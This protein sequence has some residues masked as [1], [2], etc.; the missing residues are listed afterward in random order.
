MRIHL[1]HRAPRGTRDDAYRAINELRVD[2]M[3]TTQTLRG[4]SARGEGVVVVNVRFVAPHRR[5]GEICIRGP[6]HQR[7]RPLWGSRTLLVGLTT[8][9]ARSA[10]GR[11]RPRDDLRYDAPLGQRSVDELVT[12]LD[13]PSSG[14]RH[15]P[16][17]R[18]KSLWQYRTTTA[19]NACNR[20]GAETQRRASGGPCSQAAFSVPRLSPFFCP[21]SARSCSVGMLRSG[22]GR[23]R[24]CCESLRNVRSVV[25]SLRRG[26]SLL[27]PARIWASRLAPIG[28]RGLHTSSW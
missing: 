5:H 23:M 3:R 10:P 4:D 24:W 1:Y 8:G 13:G 17:G 6:G 16:V 15:G 9:A 28:C 22:D 18:D 21:A 25:S 14:A 26:G 19:P 11:R 27:V 7:A 12:D 2:G 20:S